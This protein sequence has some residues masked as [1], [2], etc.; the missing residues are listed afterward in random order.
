M[1][2]AIVIAVA[3][4]FLLVL[5][6][7]RY[8]EYRGTR[9]LVCPETDQVVGAEVRAFTAARTW[10]AGE[11]RF[12]I[13]RCSRWPEREGCDQACAPQVARSPRDTLVQAI[14]TRWYEDNTCVYC[15]KM[16]RDAGGTVVPGLCSIDGTV[17]DWNEVAPEDLPDLLGSSLAV[18]ASCELAERFRQT[19]PE[20]VTDR[21]PTPLRNRAV[22]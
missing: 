6:F 5:V 13:S 14:V 2:A 11:P 3:V 20:L 1:T 16:I 17:R 21:E 9:I 10:L 22:H 7:F 15:N 4:A 19:H 18:C 12:V 8:R